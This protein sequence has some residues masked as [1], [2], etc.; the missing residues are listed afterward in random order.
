[1]KKKLL[2][3]ITK[4]CAAIYRW[5]RIYRRRVRMTEHEL[6]GRIEAC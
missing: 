3:K 2:K 6:G 5:F 4:K 1:M